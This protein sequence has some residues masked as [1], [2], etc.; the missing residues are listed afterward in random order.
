MFFDK[1]TTSIVFI[2]FAKHRSELNSIVAVFSVFNQNVFKVLSE[3]MEG[4]IDWEEILDFNLK[5]IP[6]LLLVSCK[7][8]HFFLVEHGNIRNC[9]H[10]LFLS[11]V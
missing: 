9:I 6:N 4:K 5:G 10:K 8:L 1:F 7:L 11:L 2:E 3:N